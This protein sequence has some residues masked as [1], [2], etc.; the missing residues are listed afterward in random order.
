MNSVLLCVG[1]TMETDEVKV[2][3]SPDDWLNLLPTQQRGVIPSKNW[4]AQS[5]E[6]ASPTALYLRL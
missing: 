6:V 3:K 1:G 5:D 2:P 4:T